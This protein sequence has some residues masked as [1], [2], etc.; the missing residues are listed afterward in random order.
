MNPEVANDLNTLLAYLR[1][2][3]VVGLVKEH[4]WKHG[5]AAPP[6]LLKEQIEKMEKHLARS[7]NT[8]ARHP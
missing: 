7:Q 8:D 6:S 1:D 5:N 2:F 4:Y 3:D